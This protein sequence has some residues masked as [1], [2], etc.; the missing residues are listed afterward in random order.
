MFSF[1]IN[2]FKN[3]H[4]AVVVVLVVGLG[5]LVIDV[6]VVVVVVIGGVYGRNGGWVRLVLFSRCNFSFIT[7][8]LLSSMNL[9]NRSM[10]T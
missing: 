6:V 8:L 7:I 10:W 4:L 2:T 9:K 5:V 1:G 3:K